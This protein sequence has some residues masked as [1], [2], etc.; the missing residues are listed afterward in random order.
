[1]D[2]KIEELEEKVAFLEKRI[3]LLEKT[4]KKRKISK[5]LKFIVLVI[6]YSLALFSLWKAYDYIVH[7]VPN[8][9]NQEVENTSNDLNKKIQELWPF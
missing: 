7:E 3:E 1:M 9:I 6:F 4:E 2:K 8:M 5:L